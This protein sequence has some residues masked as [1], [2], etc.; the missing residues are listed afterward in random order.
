MENKDPFITKHLPRTDLSKESYENLYNGIK[1]YWG[2]FYRDWETY[3][4]S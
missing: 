4:I 1:N 2:T 3:S